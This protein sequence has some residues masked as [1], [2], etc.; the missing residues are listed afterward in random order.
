MRL[1]KKKKKKP[2]Y[3]KDRYPMYDIGDFTYGKPEILSWGE[4][5]TVKIG[6]FCSISSG[7]KIFLGGD[8]RTDWVTTYPFNILWDCA[9]HIKGHP[10][11]KGDVIIGNDV[12]IGAD[13]TILS[14]VTIG[15]GAVV[16][17][18]S[19]VIKD[20]PPYAVVA[21][22]PAKFIKYRFNEDIIARLLV[23][24]WWSWDEKKIESFLPLMLNSDISPFLKKSE[25]YDGKCHE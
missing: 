17:S 6:A 7:V 20:V 22:N 5:T 8:H 15:D 23:I 10:K 25:K 12:W 21:G 13:A 24:Q 9:K 19:L 2:K 16:G 18:K 4:G 14:G 11:S 3:T 1:F